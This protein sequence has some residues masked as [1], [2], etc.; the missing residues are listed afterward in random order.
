MSIE[1]DRHQRRFLMALALASLLWACA[2]HAT[3][4][5]F[6]ARLDAA[7]AGVPSS[8]GDG[9]AL[10]S[11][12]DA[13]GQLAWTV[14][15]FD[16]SSAVN[17]ADIHG[18]AAAG[19]TASVV[20]PFTVTASPITGSATITPTQA[21]DLLAGLWYVDIHTDNNPGGEIRGQI[22]VLGETHFTFRTAQYC[23]RF[24]EGRAMLDPATLQLSWTI[25]YA[26]ADGDSE[27]VGIPGFSDHNND[28]AQP[29]E[30]E[31]NKPSGSATLTARQ[32]AELT[33][34]Y[35][36]YRAFSNDFFACGGTLQADVEPDSPRLT[37]ISTRGQV[38][39]GDG[40]LIAGFV[41]SGQPPATKSIVVRARGP[42]LGL[43][44]ALADPVLQL[45]YPDGTV[46]T[47]DNF[48][49]QGFA[50][51]PTRYAPADPHEAGLWRTLAPGA[52]TVVVSGA[53]GTTGVALAEVF[54]VDNADLPLSGISTRGPVSGGDNV[55]IG[56]FAVD[57][58]APRTVVVRAR[59]PSLAGAVASPVL[60]N[61]TLTLVR[62]SDGAVI[63]TNDDWQSAPNAAD[64]QASGMQ[65]GDARESA[66][67]ITLDPGGYTAI[68]SG[69]GGTSGIG[70]VEVFPA[71]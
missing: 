65:P 67:L 42:S 45:V 29:L 57:G 47:N 26:F 9:S 28:P 33:N 1:A 53:G 51:V 48:G 49:D 56:G 37:A 20:V 68:V 35:W 31:A 34:G 32:A 52:Y 3:T 54:E 24:L 4:T 19:A 23:S 44:G 7:Q 66:I 60:A 11:Y 30:V 16:L 40:V 58:S 2:A 61:P 39:T 27:L 5:Y 8:M 43:P 59:G 22:S 6:K 38:L 71:Q 17:A 41:I 64:I 50:Q 25:D 10:F 46:V 70:I 13:S 62:S 12:D 18:P 55:L 15:Y 14:N 69:V 63:A 36:Y 21:A